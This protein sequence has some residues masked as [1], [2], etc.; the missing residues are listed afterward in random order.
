MAAGTDAARA[1]QA[2][3][4][5]NGMECGGADRSGT[6]TSEASGRGRLGI[7]LAA[8]G[9]PAYITP[10]RSVDLP[11]QR[12]IEDLRTRSAE[13][14]DAA[15]QGGIRYFDVARSYG[16]AERFLRAWVDA[17][18][19]ADDIVVGSKW[20]YRYVGDWRT[21]A[22][23]HEVKDHSL[24]AFN[25]QLSE[26][27]EILGNLLAIYHIHSVTPDTGTLND[28]DLL[29]ALA[30]LRDS[31]VEIGLS[32]S[33]PDQSECIREALRVRIAG[34]PLFTSVQAT[35]NPLEP[36]AGAALREAAAEG[37]RVIVKECLANGRLAPGRS[38][39]DTNAAQIQQ[40]A[41][42]VGVG[43]D[44][45]ALA[46][47]L[48]QPW[49]WRVLSGAAT[50]AQV[51]SNLAGADIRIGAEHLAAALEAAESPQQYWS[52]RSARA[53]R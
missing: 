18:Q 17:R 6:G 7:G 50:T 40:L 22:R 21:D 52:K 12:S 8:V 5:S 30:R 32:V 48:A 15:Y 44:Q 42:S 49:A 11:G 43:I 31:G 23:V 19:V 3:E 35:W 34:A 51:N 2:A 26:S 9:R 28:R 14:L 25:R 53:W 38:E 16:H 10:G 36:S 13:V 24:A 45:F 33:G 37:V 1:R 20:G 29:A 46:I 27:R 41:D 4:Q 47:A 39:T